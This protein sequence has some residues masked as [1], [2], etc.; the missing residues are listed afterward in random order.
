MVKYG[1]PIV[2][3]VALAI[4]LGT[5]HRRLHNASPDLPIAPVPEQRPPAISWPPNLG[6]PG[7]AVTSRDRPITPNLAAPLREGR[8]SRAT[9]VDGPF[10]MSASVDAAC[11]TLSQ[12]GA[13]AICE[14]LRHD[15]L[16]MADEPRDPAW[17]ADME[18][19]LQNL[20]DAQKSDDISVRNVECRTT[21]CALELVRLSGRSYGFIGYFL[22]IENPIYYQ[23]SWTGNF[24]VGTETGST[25]DEIVSLFTYRRR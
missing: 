15:L 10:P 13:D 14:R 11:K 3:L 7:S 22:P 2:A 4:V 20:I 18:A 5:Q 25:G 23:L 6:P 17:A 1:V 19:K 12:R 9:I 16:V 21:Y 24:A 8:Q